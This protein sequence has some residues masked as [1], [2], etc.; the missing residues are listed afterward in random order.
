M[1]A[2]DAHVFSFATQEKTF[3]FESTSLRIFQIQD[4]IHKSISSINTSLSLSLSLSTMMNPYAQ[5]VMH[6][7]RSFTTFVS[8]SSTATTTKL[9]NNLS[10]FLLKPVPVPSPYKY[11][12]SFSSSP[13]GSDILAL[14]ES[15]N[16]DLEGRDIANAM[17]S[18]AKA[19]AVCFDVDSTVIQEEGIVSFR[20]CDM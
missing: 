5:L 9:I 10:P 17:E 15:Q 14:F 18:L 19:D 11:V 3:P 13:K 16:K 6:S 7:R 4:T 12:R 8:S 20:V 2:Y 1:C